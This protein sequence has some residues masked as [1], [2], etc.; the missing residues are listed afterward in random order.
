MG[1]SIT[2]RGQDTLFSTPAVGVITI[3][4]QSGDTG[5]QGPAGAAG[6]QGIQGVKGDTGNTGSAGSQGI[7][8]DTGAQGTQGVQ[9][10]QGVPGNDGATGPA[11]STGATGATGSTGSTGATGSAG[12]NG[13]NGTNGATWRDGSGVPSN[14]LGAN[15]D[16]YLDDATGNV[17]L[18]TAGTYSIVANIKGATGSTGSQGIQGNTGN[19]GSTGS[20]GATGPGVVTGGTAGQILSKI[21]STD[22]NTQWVNRT[23]VVTKTGNYTVTTEDV[24]IADATGGVITITLPTAVGVVRSITI[25][26]INSGANAVNIATTSSQTMDG[27]T[28]AAMSVANQSLTFVSDN[29]NWFII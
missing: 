27:S 25:K 22:F 4:S 2:Y 10:I 26:R 17:Y 18:R 9:G 16:Y 24:I 6:P 28:T 14:G 23:A 21:N 19:T 12:S 11:G 5:P 15:G 3:S 8:G 29:A 20:T 1:I 13:T 7:K